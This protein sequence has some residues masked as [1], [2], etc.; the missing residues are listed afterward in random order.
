MLKLQCEKCNYE[1]EKE[2]PPK[3]CPYCAAE[4]FIIPYKPAQSFLDESEN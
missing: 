3:R 1:F 2:N 4:D